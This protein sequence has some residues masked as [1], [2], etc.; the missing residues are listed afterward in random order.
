MN[1][2]SLC[3]FTR[4]EPAKASIHYWETLSKPFERV[5]VDFTCLLRNVY[6]IVLVDAYTK[7]LEA[8]IVKNITTATT[9]QVFREYFSTY[10]IP[11]T[12]LVSD[13]GVQFTSEEF[14]KLLIKVF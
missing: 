3:Q 14:Q 13:H 12:V 2:C 4:A 8:R 9:V 10:G 5:H 7:W 6:F 11:P 1:N